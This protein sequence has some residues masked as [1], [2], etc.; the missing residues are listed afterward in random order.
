METQTSFIIPAGDPGLPA[1]RLE[2]TE[3]FYAEQRIAEVAFVNEHKAPELLST[4][5]QAYLSLVKMRAL[6]EMEAGAAQSHLNR[7]RSEV[8]LEVATEV[9]KK[10]GLATSKDLREA[11]VDGDIQYQE[12]QGRLQAIEVHLEW[13]KGKTKGIEMAYTSVKKILGDRP[14]LGGSTTSGYTSPDHKQETPVGG[15]IQSKVIYTPTDRKPSGFGGA[16]F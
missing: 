2:M 1:L 10:K 16:K 9:L 5:N 13:I 15:T 8:I 14:R 3:I 7:R 4:F 6:L 11:V 12:L